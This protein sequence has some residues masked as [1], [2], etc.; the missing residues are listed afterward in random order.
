MLFNSFS[1]LL[2]FPAAT[3]VYF[4]L[5][6]RF[7]WAFLLIASIAFYSA[8]IPYYVLVLS[9]LIVIDYLAAL[10]IERASPERKKVFLLASVLSVIAALAVFK[11]FDFLSV[12]LTALAKFLNWNYSLP[13]LSLVLPIG[14]SFH[15]FQSLS[16]VI[17]VYRGRQKAERHFG[18]YALYVM[19]YPQLVAGPIERPQNLLRQFYEEHRFDLERVAHGL[20]LMVWGFLKKWSSPT[21]SPA[22]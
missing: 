1:F 8:F 12:N 11:Y 13:T 21:G 7:R 10:F 20:A 4:I 19:F 22:A 3:A 16:Y 5:P 2:F 17:E 6:H 14:L 9:A 15:T 18:I